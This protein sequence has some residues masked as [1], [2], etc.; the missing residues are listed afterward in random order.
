[1]SA[2]ANGTRPE[3]FGPSD[4]GVS[5]DFRQYAH[6][7]KKWRHK[8]GYGVFKNSIA[9]HVISGDQAVYHTFA[10]IESNQL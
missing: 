2:T 10:F 9:L 6:E 8:S 7:I 5:I 4:A 3:A 1:M